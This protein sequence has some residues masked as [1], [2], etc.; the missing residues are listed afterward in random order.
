MAKRTLQL[1]IDCGEKT[2]A[3]APGKFCQWCLTTRFGTR[4][5]C[6]LFRDEQS[7]P[8][9]LRSAQRWSDDGWK[10]DGWLQRCQ[11]CLE[12]EVKE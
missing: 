7:N 9:R 6:G 8:V 5:I 11:Q 4:W 12:T 2:C 1:Q 10:D 3:S